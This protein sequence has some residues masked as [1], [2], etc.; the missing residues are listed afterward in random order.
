MN[1]PP[2]N[3][4]NYEEYY[5]FLENLE[6]FFINEKNYEDIQKIHVPK[7]G[8]NKYFILILQNINKLILLVITYSKFD[9]MSSEKKESL[10][11]YFKTTLSANLLERNIL[12]RCLLKWKNYLFKI[13]LNIYEKINYIVKIVHTNIQQSQIYKELRY[14]E[15]SSKNLSG[16]FNDDI[17]ILISY[18]LRNC[19][20]FINNLHSKNNLKS[21]LLNIFFDVIKIEKYFVRLLLNQDQN[22]EPIFP[23]IKKQQ[24][25]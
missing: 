3:Q 7:N 2:D 17:Y 12:E 6:A 13:M 5:L 25:E 15:S 23:V 24:M 9:T 11:K 16:G 1:T 14:K 8:V 20:I 21:N 4:Y 22:F 10:K 18:F 19:D